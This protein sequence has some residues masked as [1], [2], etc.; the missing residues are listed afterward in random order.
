VP[1]AQRTCSAAS[2]R[3]LTP[4]RTGTL[5]RGRWPTPSPARTSS[6]SRRSAPPDADALAELLSN[7]IGT[8]DK[9]TTDS[10]GHRSEMASGACFLTTGS[11]ASSA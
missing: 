1:G 6:R 10:Y 9:G 2:G 11:A 8:L 3:S 7:Y 4:A 5:G